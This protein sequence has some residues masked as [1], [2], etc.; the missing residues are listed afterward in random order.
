MSHIS[1]FCVQIVIAI[2]EK[3]NE[4]CHEQHFLELMC[5]AMYVF[6]LVH[7]QKKKEWST[8]FCVCT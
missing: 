6:T 3:R 7:Q 4:G 1:L 8:S 5:Y 2:S